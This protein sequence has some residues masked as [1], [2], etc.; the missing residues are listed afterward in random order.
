MNNSFILLISGTK[1][2]GVRRSPEF[3]Q[4]TRRVSI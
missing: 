1:R 3:I 4:L 2:L